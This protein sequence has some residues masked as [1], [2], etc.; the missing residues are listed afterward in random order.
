MKLTILGI[1][2]SFLTCSSGFVVPATLSSSARSV[3][4]LFAYELVPEIDGG[5]ELVAISTSPVSRMKNLGEV[6]GKTS[7]DGKVFKFWMTA[8]GEGALIKD[9]RAT[10]LKDASKKANFPGF[11]K[12]RRRKMYESLFGS[13]VATLCLTSI[14][15]PLFLG[16]SS[17]VC[18]ASN[19]RFCHSRGSH[20]IR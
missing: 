18:N 1:I 15:A 4:V 13:Q 5:E 9:Y 12:V 17:T 16:S 2:S 14:F 3:S 20:Q 6:A 7:K 11:R 10:L 8:V 19:Y